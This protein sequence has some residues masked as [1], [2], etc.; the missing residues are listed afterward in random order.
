[1]PSSKIG[2]GFF[3]RRP[4]HATALDAHVPRIFDL[5][6]RAAVSSDNVSP[7]SSPTITTPRGSWSHPA[8]SMKRSEFEDGTT[9]TGDDYLL[10]NFPNSSTCMNDRRRSLCRMVRGDPAV[11]KGE[12][13]S[14][15]KLKGFRCILGATARFSFAHSLLLSQ[16]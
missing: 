7:A 10:L 5:R 11:Q 6:W 15:V 9:T 2:I 12:I 4:W 8:N 14:C 16:S 3:G 13:D 1:V